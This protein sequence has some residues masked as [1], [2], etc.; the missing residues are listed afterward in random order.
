MTAF[1]KITETDLEYFRALLPGRVFAG[2]A[3]SGKRG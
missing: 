1:N 3:I 2:E